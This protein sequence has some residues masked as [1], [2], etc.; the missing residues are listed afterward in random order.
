MYF[1]YIERGVWLY[2]IFRKLF[3]TIYFFLA[4]AAMGIMFF[5]FYYLQWPITNWIHGSKKKAEKKKA[6]LEKKVK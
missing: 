2:P 4:L 5:I 1:T 3:G 6:K